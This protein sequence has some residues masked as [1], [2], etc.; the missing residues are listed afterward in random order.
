MNAGE[1]HHQSQSRLELMEDTDNEK[2]KIRIFK[3]KTQEGFIKNKEALQ[4]SKIALTCL[5]KKK[6]NHMF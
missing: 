6:K 3:S 2:M 4:T 1:D 5:Q